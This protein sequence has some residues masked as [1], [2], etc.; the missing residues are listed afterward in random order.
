VLANGI[1]EHK[2]RFEQL[3]AKPTTYAAPAAPTSPSSSDN[4]GISQRLVQLD[5]DVAMKVSQLEQGIMSINKKLQAPGSTTAAVGGNVESRLA[6]CEVDLIF[7]RQF[8]H[9]TQRHLLPQQ[10]STLVQ[11]LSGYQLGLQAA[12][13]EDDQ[14]DHH[15]WAVKHH[16]FGKLVESVSALHGHFTVAHAAKEGGDV[17][18]VR[19]MVASPA[20]SQNADAQKAFLEKKN[21]EMESKNKE[22]EEKLAQSVERNKTLEKIVNLPKVATKQMA[23]QDDSDKRVLEKLMEAEKQYGSLDSALHEF[24]SRL[25]GMEEH[26]GSASKEGDDLDLAKAEAMTAEAKRKADAME[27]RL[28]DLERRDTTQ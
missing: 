11:K 6:K 19:D 10:A 9:K 23:V 26:P 27:K 20:R 3:E 1:D 2:R 25:K 22:M 17:N 14:V 5:H 28:E 18:K 24:E 4:K 12:A 16:L 8:R 15:G 13:A 7:E 21:K